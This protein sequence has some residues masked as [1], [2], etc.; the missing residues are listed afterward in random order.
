M[1]NPHFPEFFMPAIRQM[2]IVCFAL[3]GA[4]PA[5]AQEASESAGMQA[6]RYSAKELKIEFRPELTQEQAIRD[7]LMLT[8]L[9]LTLRGGEVDAGE[10][11]DGISTVSIEE[12][13]R[14]SLLLPYKR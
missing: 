10:K 11:N 2:L 8:P 5:V 12:A 14:H 13:I 7:R 3:T 4:A 6:M 1:N 9:Q